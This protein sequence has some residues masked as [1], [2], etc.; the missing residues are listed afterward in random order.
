MMFFRSRI[1]FKILYFGDQENDAEG[2]FSAQ[3][4]WGTKDLRH[5][6]YIVTY[7]YNSS[8]CLYEWVHLRQKSMKQYAE[9]CLHYKTLLNV[10]G[11]MKLI[12][13]HCL[14]LCAHT[15]YDQMV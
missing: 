1:N 6:H 4:L 9:N 5:T 7:K 15:Q 11:F 8:M 2:F 14:S 10:Y 12:F 3:P 13:S